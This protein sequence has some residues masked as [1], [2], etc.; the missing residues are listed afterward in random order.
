MARSDFLDFSCLA[1]ASRRTA[2]AVSNYF[3]ARLS[4]LDLNVAQFGLLAAV[5]KMPGSTLSA[6]G[7]A[8]LL[9]ESTLARNFNVLERRGLV[10]AEGG[11]GRGGKQ[12]TLTAEGAAL[13]AEASR[14]WKRTNQKLSSELEDHG[15]EAG[16]VFLKA[17]GEASERLRAKNETAG[18]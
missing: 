10:E 8:M 17:L 6:I 18:G 4:H 3:N 16:R 14:I 15:V 7:E 9:E 5:A 12:V 2:R 1:Y 13:F 11:R